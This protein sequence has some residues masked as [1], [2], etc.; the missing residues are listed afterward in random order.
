MG[1]PGFREVGVL[2]LSLGIGSAKP[3]NSAQ[4]VGTGGQS[5][6]VRV[7]GNQSLFEV[8]NVKWLSLHT[9]GKTASL[10]EQS[11]TLDRTRSLSFS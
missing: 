5:F 7:D 9:C 4:S 10:P 6:L 2:L 8:L 11:T 3:Q 1:H